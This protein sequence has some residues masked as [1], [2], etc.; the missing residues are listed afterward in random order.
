MHVSPTTPHGHLL[1]LSFV[2]CAATLWRSR[3]ALHLVSAHWLCAPEVHSTAAL[4][5]LPMVARLAESAHIGTQKKP[6]AL[7]SRA[8]LVPQSLPVLSELP[9]CLTPVHMFQICPCDSE[10]PLCLTP[11]HI[12]QT[13]P[14]AS[15]LPLC[16]RPIHVPQSFSCAPFLRTWC[17][18]LF[19]GL[20]KNV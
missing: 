10:L 7:A 4:A 11:V 6:S 20:P 18:Y 12:L 15:E 17:S 9:L 1:A 8:V 16:L 19:G 5:H 14:C 13:C 3:P 2:A